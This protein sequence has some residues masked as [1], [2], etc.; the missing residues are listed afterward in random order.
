MDLTEKKKRRKKG[1]AGRIW[2]GPA[3][4]GPD[5][6]DGSP[7]SPATAERVPAS[8]GR[9]IRNRSAARGR[10]ARGALHGGELTLAGSG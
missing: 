2:P 5:R 10:R 6:P 1:G 3:R 8:R 7:A 9:P 4:S